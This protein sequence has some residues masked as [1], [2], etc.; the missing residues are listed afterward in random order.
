MLST[1]E[2]GKFD[3]GA[4][5]RKGVNPENPDGKRDGGGFPILA[6]G[7]NCT[8]HANKQDFN[9]LE[10]GHGFKLGEHDRE[11]CEA[12]IK[13]QVAEVT[14]EHRLETTGWI[15]HEDTQRKQCG[16]SNGNDAPEFTR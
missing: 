8:D 12:G 6:G 5:H 10:Q 3:Q 14:R 4:E 1:T 16:E 15:A 2:D 13:C 9:S 7:D 11:Q